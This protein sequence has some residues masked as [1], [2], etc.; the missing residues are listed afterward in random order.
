[1]ASAKG[2][3]SAATGLRLIF[4]SAFSNYRR[5]AIDLFFYQIR[6]VRAENKLIIN[7]CDSTKLGYYAN[8]TLL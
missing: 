4:S 2:F 7:D 3:Y 5:L 8:T 6:Q 1:M